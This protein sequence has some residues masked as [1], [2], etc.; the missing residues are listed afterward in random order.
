MT[1][2]E[3]YAPKIAH[4][5]YLSLPIK[6]SFEITEGFIYS[7]QERTIHG[8]FLHGGIDYHVGYD[9]PV[10][11]S[12]S[13]YAVVG[14]HRR[15][16]KNKDNTIKLFR[17]EPIGTGF[18]YFVQIYH[19][20]YISKVSSG[21][22]TQYGHLARIAKGLNLKELPPIRYNYLDRIRKYYFYAS[23]RKSFNPKV[24]DKKITQ[25]KKILD[26]YEWVN[27]LYGYNLHKELTDTETYFY[28]LDEIE[29][30]YK[31]KSPYVK[32][33]EQGEV[34]GYV[35]SS[36]LIYGS[37]TYEEGKNDVY[38]KA[39][40]TWDEVHLHFEEAGRDPKTRL[41]IQQRDPYGI[42]KSWKWYN[43]RGIKENTLFITESIN[44]N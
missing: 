40:T 29:Q 30:L 20:E 4:H 12:A 17:G 36:A 11:A 13:G 2:K 5:R 28:R 35:G 27:Y 24:I 22:I 14:Y 19:P 33:V 26:E 21:R 1:F 37:P 16:V 23:K 10:H 32:W 34:I 31:N 3:R 44:D 9:T 43:H 6:S 25:T 7:S 18:G 39:F 15:V 41:K 42:Y 8:R 38:V